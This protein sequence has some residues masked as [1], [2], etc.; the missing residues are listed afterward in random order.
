MGGAG[1]FGL[2][3]QGGEVW[4]WRGTGC[5]VPGL[6]EGMPIAANSTAGA[7]V[8]SAGVASALLLLEELW[9][10]VSHLLSPA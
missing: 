5:A 8:S 3:H 1:V 9:K 2:A 7:A 10:K 6:E 4:G